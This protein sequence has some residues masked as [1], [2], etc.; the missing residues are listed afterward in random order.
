[1]WG[2]YEYNPGRKG[3]RADLSKILIVL[4][5]SDSRALISALPMPDFD[6]YE[7]TFS[8][9]QTGQ[10]IV[11]MLKMCGYTLDDVFITN[12]FKCLLPNDRAPARQEYENCL[13]LLREQIAD[14]SPRGILVFGEKPSELMFNGK[15]SQHENYEGIPAFVSVHPSV[16]WLRSDELCNSY[17]QRIADF[18]RSLR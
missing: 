6:S 17:C 15:K 8:R 9:T 2:A 3:P 1:M 18:V 12:I 14:F 16:P 10:I 13:L 7:L 5:R 11:R 4:H